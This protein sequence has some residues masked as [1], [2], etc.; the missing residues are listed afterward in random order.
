MMHTQKVC[1]NH[2][3]DQLKVC[4]KCRE[5]KV[6]SEFVKDK[7]KKDGLTSKCKVCQRELT[8][9][10]YKANSER[11]KENSR[12]WRKHNSDRKRKT[13]NW[14]KEKYREINTARPESYFKDREGRFKYCQT[15][16]QDKPLIRFII[17]KL[18]FD[19]FNSKCMDCVN[20]YV[21]HR[22]ATDPEYRI[23]CI[24]RNDLRKLFKLSGLKREKRSMELL[25]IPWKEL[26]NG[27]L[28]TLPE[29]YTEQDWLNRKLHVDHKIPI[30]WFKRLY[31]TLTE[32]LIK[33]INH[34]SNLQLIPKE[35][36]ISKGDRYGHGI[37]NEIILYED[38]V[39]TEQLSTI[40]H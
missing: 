24:L 29:G 16:D 9:N 1:I 20:E 39:I 15:C 21:K 18:N 37:N 22:Y 3:M 2:F 32:D 12:N 17:N 25:G 36:N 40:S 6:H 7:S 33:R 5:S 26:Y 19:G 35:Q 13:D 23:K 38:W 30:A 28:K 10:W 34:I 11:H 4:S 14:N 8:R 31:G 27:L